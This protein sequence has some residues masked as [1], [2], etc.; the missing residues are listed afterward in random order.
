MSVF[1][2]QPETAI[3]YRLL[4]IVVIELQDRQYSTLSLSC[5]LHCNS[6]MF[7]VLFHATAATIVASE[8][9]KKKH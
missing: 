8:L 6:M 5:K 7:H 1:E 4:M 9:H 3:Y 2:L